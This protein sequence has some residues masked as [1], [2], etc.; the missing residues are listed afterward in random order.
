MKA[1]EVL[2]AETTT[3]NLW[4]FIDQFPMG[5]QN[6]RKISLTAKIK[7]YIKESLWPVDCLVFPPF[8]RGF[9]NNNLIITVYGFQIQ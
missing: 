4:L 1:G 3:S 9:T 2:M 6:L 7:N 5:A 8:Q